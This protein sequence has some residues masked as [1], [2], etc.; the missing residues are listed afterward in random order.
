M[1]NDSSLWCLQDINAH[2]CVTGKPISQGG[3]HGRISA[4]GRGVFHGIENFI[5]EASY[6][7]QLGMSPGFQDKSFVIQVRSSSSPAGGNF[8]FLSESLE[9]HVDH[10]DAVELPT[11]SHS[12]YMYNDYINKVM[13]TVKI[14]ADYCYI[15]LQILR[16]I[17]A[18][19]SLLLPVTLSIF[20]PWTPLQWLIWATSFLQFQLLNNSRNLKTLIMTQTSI[21]VFH[22]LWGSSDIWILQYNIKHWC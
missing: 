8:L 7:S 13:S 4:T 18:E 5:N 9:R 20:Q 11:N 12:K 6:M 10:T 14:S 3:I 1:F 22:S 2:A 17:K 16:N 15:Q 19:A 21:F